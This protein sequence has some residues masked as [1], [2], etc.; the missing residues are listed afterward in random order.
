MLWVGTV[1]EAVGLQPGWISLNKMLVISSGEMDEKEWR[2]DGIPLLLFWS[3]HL[4]FSSSLADAFVLSFLTPWLIVTH[5]F[6]A[7]VKARHTWSLFFWS[8]ADLSVSLT[9]LSSACCISA[10]FL[11]FTAKERAE[12]ISNL[13]PALWKFTLVFSE[14][15]HMVFMAQMIGSPLILH[16]QFT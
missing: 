1:A 9:P 15:C 14:G 16:K 5:L 6:V 8:N 3:T 7:I 2:S 10:Y 11:S 4:R 13:R 12:S